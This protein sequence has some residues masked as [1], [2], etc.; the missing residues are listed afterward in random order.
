MEKESPKPKPDPFKGEL[1]CLGAG[2]SGCPYSMGHLK[3]RR[4][5][6]SVAHIY[7]PSYSGGRD[8]EN[9][10]LKP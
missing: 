10:S 5:Q 3:L 6:V 1:G 4:A 2:Y 7:N 9:F 8:Q